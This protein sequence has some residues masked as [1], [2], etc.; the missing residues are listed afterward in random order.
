MHNYKIKITSYTEEGAVTNDYFV[1]YADTEEQAQNICYEYDKQKFIKE[2]GT[3][4]FKMYKVEL[5]VNTYKKI[6]DKDAFFKQF[7]A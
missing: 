4:G 1:K 2:D 6:D 5:F 7:E 3:Q